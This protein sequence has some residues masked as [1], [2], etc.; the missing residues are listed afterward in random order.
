MEFGLAVQNNG[1][2]ASAES[3]DA[4]AE[5]ATRFG[6][7]SLWLA[8]HLIVSRAGGPRADEWFAEY[9]V[10]EHEWIFEAL[11][12]A[13]YLGARHEKLLLG[14]GVVVP[15][16]RDAPQLAKELATLDSLTGGRLIVGVGVGDEEDELEYQ[17]LGKGD[18]F[19]VRGAYLEESIALFRHL[20]SGRTDPFVGRFH[21]LDDFLFE[22][23]PPQG[24]DLP[25]WTGGRSARALAR[26]GV[27]TD[28]YVGARWA[29]ARFSEEWP[30]VIERARLNGRRRPYLA[31]RVRIRPG[32]EPDEI[33]SL[34]GTPGSMV[35]GLLEYEAAGADEVIAVLEA[36]LPDDI[37]RDAGRFQRE[38]VEPYREASARRR[39]GG[40]PTVPAET[41]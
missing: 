35:A 36:V 12:S 41:A 17:N 19:H 24:A 23:P 31:I 38:V 16:M 14:L 1:V 5:V 25:I 30:A 28:G 2:G 39:A 22:P 6:W 13:M 15:P 9:N 3:M 40:A 29:P 26:I 8:D 4:S 10:H 11:L 33:W 18:R 7:R 34:C 32:E 37:E 27:I 21:R 20:W